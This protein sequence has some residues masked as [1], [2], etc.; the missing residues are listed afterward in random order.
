MSSTAIKIM[1]VLTMAF[2]TASRGEALEFQK[3]KIKLAGITLTVEMAET[4]EQQERGLMNRTSLEKDA[5][6][7]FAFSEPQILTFWMKNTLIPLSIGYF[8]AKMKLID[9]IEMVPAVA[10]DQHPKVYPSS[11]PAQYALEM[12]KGWFAAHHIK[13]GVKFEY[14]AEKPSTGAATTAATAAKPAAPSASPS[15]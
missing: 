2:V 15:K 13:P 7:L 11:K 3:R 5:G 1:I 12:T 4:P 8:D 9:V 6:M 10:G 14:L